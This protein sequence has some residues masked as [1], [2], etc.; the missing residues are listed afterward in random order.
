MSAILNSIQLL[1]EKQP[2]ELTVMGS[3][4]IAAISTISKTV[5]LNAAETLA[6]GQLVDLGHES[7]F[8]LV[9]ALDY[10]DQNRMGQDPHRYLQGKQRG[11]CDRNS[12]TDTSKEIQLFQDAIST[13]QRPQHDAIE[14][15][16]GEG[17][18]I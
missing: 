2:G 9:Y 1:L 3:A 6:S 15:E 14:A 7:S 17:C 5:D 8:A 12:K 4:I 10:E 11:A 18:S 13:D 16:G